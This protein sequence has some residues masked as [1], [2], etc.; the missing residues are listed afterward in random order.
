MYNVAFEEHDRGHRDSWKYE[1]GQFSVSTMHF[2]QSGIG[3]GP[4][5]RA[6]LGWGFFTAE[7]R[8]LD[9]GRYKRFSEHEQYQNADKQGPALLLGVGYGFP[10]RGGGTRILTTLSYA[11]RPGVQGNEVYFVDEDGNR[12]DLPVD[13]EGGVRVLS[14]TLGALF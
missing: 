14:I 12:D 4:F 7:S 13:A 6:D 5:V 1:S 10:V 8:E 3:K 11:L 2:V 9:K